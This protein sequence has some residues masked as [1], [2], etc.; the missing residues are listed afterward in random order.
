MLANTAEVRVGRLLEVNVRVGYRTVSDVDTLFDEIDR[1]VTKIP[2]SQR[3]VTCA[4][5]RFCPVMAPE[6]SA[7]LAKRI[8]RYNSR[9]ERSV[10]VVRP[11]S[12]TAVMQFARLI[13]EANFPDRKAFLSVQS[14]IDWLDE[15]LAPEESARLREFLNAKDSGSRVGRTP[16][17]R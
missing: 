1:E 6:T 13:R 5:W 15:I 8:E 14:A 11:D 2:P 10:A 16:P 4:D 12:P 9:T 7:R 17:E 3:I